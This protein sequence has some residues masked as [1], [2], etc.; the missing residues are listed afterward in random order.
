MFLVG[1]E[2]ED[3]TLH[4]WPR[5]EKTPLQS[6]LVEN[7]NVALFQV[8]TEHVENLLNFMR[9]PPEMAV[10]EWIKVRTICISKSAVTGTLKHVKSSVAR[11]VGIVLRWSSGYGAGG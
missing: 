9:I 4:F 3:L 6:F 2:S 11:S 1:T 5:H 8:I 7:E 10:L